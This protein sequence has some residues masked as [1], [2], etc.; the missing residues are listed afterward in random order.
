MFDKKKIFDTKTIQPD[1]ADSHSMDFNC[2]GR[3]KNSCNFARIIT[4]G[5]HTYRCGLT[6]DMVI[7]CAGT[8]IEKEGCLFWKILIQLQKMS[9]QNQDLTVYPID[10]N[11]R[12]LEDQIYE[13]RG[14]E[15][16]LMMKFKK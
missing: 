10:N 7:E 9:G 5:K 13:K 4:V 15:G 11:L 6:G 16:P 1:L 2:E 3:P 8:D 14:N 12:I